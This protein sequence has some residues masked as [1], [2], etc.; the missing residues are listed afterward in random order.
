MKN[1]YSKAKKF[2]KK[3]AIVLYFLQISLIFG[4]VEDSWVFIS[5]YP[6]N[7]L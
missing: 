4:S 3:N 6:F 2:N 1:R 7:L 5:A